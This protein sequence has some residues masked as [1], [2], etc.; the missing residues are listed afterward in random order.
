MEDGLR[1]SRLHIIRYE[2]LVG[3]PAGVLRDLYRFVDC[4]PDIRH[5]DIF[6]DRNRAYFETWDRW[7]A[8]PEYSRYVPPLIARF[9]S[10]IREFG[11]S[12]VDPDQNW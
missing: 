10:Q 5:I 7:M 6:V 2:E 4:D 1:I 9:E 12:L 11:Y 3:R 8:D